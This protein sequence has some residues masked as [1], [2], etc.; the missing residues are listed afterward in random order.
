MSFIKS[1]VSAWNFFSP[2][3]IGTLKKKLQFESFNE[4]KRYFLVVEIE[5]EECDFEVDDFQIKLFK[6]NS[7]MIVKCVNYQS[8][9]YIQEILW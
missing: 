5:G 2:Y 6:K 3:K 4:Q 8:G 9:N 1:L 7:V